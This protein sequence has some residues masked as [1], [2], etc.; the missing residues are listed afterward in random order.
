VSSEPEIL[1]RP[2]AAGP[3]DHAWRLAYRVAY[4]ALRWWWRQVPTL[5]RGAGVAVWHEG[6]LL[7][8]RTSYRGVLELPGGG[9]GRRET[10]LLAAVR[11]LE[12]ELG[13]ALPPAE[14]RHA[15]T[16]LF[17]LG[18]R[19]IEDT[20]FEWHPAARPTVCV[21]RR[22]LVWAGWLTPDE[23]ARTVMMP[24]LRRYLEGRAG[25]GDRIGTTEE[26]LVP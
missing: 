18:R 6:C 22:E 21:D 17:R 4:H 19:R 9:V 16:L 8:V 20:V 26:E 1:A 3:L 7:V 23:L 5:G 15:A 12:E 2:A 25:E 11:E 10:P 24:A 14:L 13:L